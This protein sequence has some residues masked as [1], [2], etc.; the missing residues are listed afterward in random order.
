MGVY[1]GMG[2]PL[3]HFLGV[4]DMNGE[5]Q[6]YFLRPYHCIFVH[7]HRIDRKEKQTN[8]WISDI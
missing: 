3:G 5:T 8:R 6:F 4:G 1:N 7:G 2:L